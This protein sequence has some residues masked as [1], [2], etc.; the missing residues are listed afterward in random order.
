MGPHYTACDICNLLLQGHIAG[1]V[2]RD[3]ILIDGQSLSDYRD[4]LW[5]VAD[6]Q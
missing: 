1:E 3:Q 4:A 2:A 6:I 5:E